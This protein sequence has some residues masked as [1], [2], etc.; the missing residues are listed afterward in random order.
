MILSE[1]LGRYWHPNF[2]RN[3]VSENVIQKEARNRRRIWRVAS[4]QTLADQHSEVEI[5]ALAT[6]D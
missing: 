6:F 5:I 2:R 4:I 3:M 1:A